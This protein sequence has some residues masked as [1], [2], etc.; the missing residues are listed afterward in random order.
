MSIYILHK[1]APIKEV[2][3]IAAT[4]MMTMMPATMTMEPQPD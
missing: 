3:K 2:A 1:D 4:Q